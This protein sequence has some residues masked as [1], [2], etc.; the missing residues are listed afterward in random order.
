[1]AAGGLKKKRR[2]VYYEKQAELAGFRQ[3]RTEKDEKILY[4][5]R[6]KD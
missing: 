1:M 3:V 5:E 4:L 2:V 6:W